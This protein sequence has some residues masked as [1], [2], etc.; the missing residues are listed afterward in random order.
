MVINDKMEQCY[1]C[2]ACVQKCPVHAIRMEDD[3]RGFRKPQID[4]TACIDCSLC[5]RV[6][7][8]NVQTATYKHG[9]EQQH[10][11]GIKRLDEKKRRES[12]SGGAFSVIA[13]Y[14]LAQHGVVY[15]VALDDALNCCYQ[16][17]VTAAEL[18]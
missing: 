8:L 15:G 17:V 5:A 14:V 6:C 18:V 12:Q 2:E 7:P 16:R 10:I 11:R 13:E 3:G 1:N 9:V 4:E